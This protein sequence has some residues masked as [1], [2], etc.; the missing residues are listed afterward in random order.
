[1]TEFLTATSEGLW[2]F[3]VWCHAV[4]VQTSLENQLSLL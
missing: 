3:G 4:S 2:Y 1:M